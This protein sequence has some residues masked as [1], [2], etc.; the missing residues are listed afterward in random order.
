V[1]E[2]IKKNE[3]FIEG[4]LVSLLGLVVFML[5]VYWGEREREREREGKTWEE[6]GER[7]CVCFRIIIIHWVATV[8]PNPMV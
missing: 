6:I 1:K 3:A 8:L 7:P 5:V 2:N 4:V